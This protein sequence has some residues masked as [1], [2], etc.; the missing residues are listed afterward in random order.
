MTVNRIH[1]LENFGSSYIILNDNTRIP[2]KDYIPTNEQFHEPKINDFKN[3]IN[4]LE[5]FEYPYLMFNN[6][7]EC[8]QMNMIKYDTS[9]VNMLNTVGLH[10]F[11]TENLMKYNDQ[12]IHHSNLDRSTF[13][14]VNNDLGLQEGIFTNPRCGQLDSVQDL[15]INNGLTNVT[16]YV[17]EHNVDNALP[18]Y[19]NI[20]F[21]W[22]DLFLKQF[23]KDTAAVNV[24]SKQELN[25]TF[26]N[27]NWRYEPFRHI[28]AAYLKNYNSK[29]SW[30]YHCTQDVFKKN[31]WFSPSEKLLTGFNALNDS[32]PLNLDIEVKLP[33]K[34]DG[35]IMDRFKLPN[36]NNMP[37][38]LTDQYTDVFC[39]IV[40]ESSFLDI[41]TY[42]S[43][44]TMTAIIN[45]MPFVI[46]GPPYA[47]RTAQEMGF[48]TF[49]KYW[50]ESY[51]TE[52]DH[53]KRM[54]KLFK[55]I[56]SIASYNKQDLVSMQQDMQDILIYNKQQIQRLKL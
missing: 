17:P 52:L 46:V 8:P 48:K 41:T 12:R 6:T 2:L 32:V 22:K 9:I 40:N 34:L 18:R 36:H 28:I 44:K 27:T 53:T 43:D 55:V 29:I 30:C 47:L 10:I 50:D 3:Y 25:Y 31:M 19:K 11:L 33:T 5:G 42:I 13:M 45:C 35:N 7:F 54:K 37:Y 38:I 21:I 51:D 15:I 1:L 23:I 14:L 16:V 24:Q 56:D 20:K 39:S 26:I 49:S 4:L